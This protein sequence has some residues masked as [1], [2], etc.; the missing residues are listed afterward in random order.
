MRA[1]ST[2]LS[3]LYKFSSLIRGFVSLNKQED[4]QSR[5]QDKIAENATENCWE[6]IL[7][8][9]EKEEDKRKNE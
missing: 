1:S 4:N 2:C 7:I 9:V 3:N 6:V 5:K 8:I